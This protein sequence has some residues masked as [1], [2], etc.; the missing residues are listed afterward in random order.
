[1]NAILAALLSLN[2]TTPSNALVFNVD[3]LTWNGQT[4]TS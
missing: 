4:L 1:M 3:P 2:L